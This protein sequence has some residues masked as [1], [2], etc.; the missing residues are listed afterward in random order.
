[1]GARRCEY[2]PPGLTIGKAAKAAGVTREAVRAHEA[3]GLLPAAERTEAGYRLYDQHDIELLTFIRRARALGLHLDDVRDVLAI[4]N[5]GTRALRHRSL[6]A[7]RPDRRD[8][9]HR[10]RA[11]S[12][13]QDTRRDPAA[14]R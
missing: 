4:R 7:R 8:R 10:H 9:H 5:G 2:A 13:V 3:R 1:M 11:A 14:G 12:P 6:P